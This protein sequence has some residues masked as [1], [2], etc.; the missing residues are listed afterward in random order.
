MRIAGPSPRIPSISSSSP[1]VIVPTPI[2]CSGITSVLSIEIVSISVCDN[3]VSCVLVR[4]ELV[5]TFL[6]SKFI[7]TT[8]EAEG[9]SIS[10]LL[11]TSG[12]HIF[13]FSQPSITRSCKHSFGC[14]SF[15]GVKYVLTCI[16]QKVDLSRRMA[17]ADR[18][19]VPHSCVFENERK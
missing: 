2:D 18:C 12:N 5:R 16:N 6:A 9:D 4:L 19:N 15:G 10:G 11:A 3:N 14:H 1:L 7:S 17:D 13:C 8:S